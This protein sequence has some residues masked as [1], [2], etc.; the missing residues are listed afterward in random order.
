MHSVSQN[1][2]TMIPYERRWEEDP[3]GAVGKGSLD[4]FLTHTVDKNGT[5]SLRVTRR[6][7]AHMIEEIEL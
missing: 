7:R 1:F 6:S 5:S 4:P 3:G 2:A